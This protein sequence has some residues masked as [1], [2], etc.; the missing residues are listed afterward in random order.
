MVD[1]R[2]SIVKHA[3]GSFLNSFTYGRGHIVPEKGA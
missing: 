2:L 3:V 1:I